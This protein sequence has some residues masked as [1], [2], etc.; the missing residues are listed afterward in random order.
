MDHPK[1][2]TC[3]SFITPK[4]TDNWDNAGFGYCDLI[5]MTC[6]MT[7]W[8]NDLRITELKPKYK[9]HM[10]GVMDGSSYRAAL[11]PSEEFYCPM[12]SDLMPAL[13]ND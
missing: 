11:Y 2:A 12:H 8:D 13:H 3:K 6:E 7:S 10:A 5:E 1:C 9:D 4:N